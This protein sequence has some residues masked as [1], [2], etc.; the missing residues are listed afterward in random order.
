MPQRARKQIPELV[1]HR[2]DLGKL[3]CV[4]PNQSTDYVGLTSQVRV[5]QGNHGPAWLVRNGVFEKSRN[6]RGHFHRPFSPT[7]YL[8]PAT[9]NLS[10]L[11]TTPYI[12]PYRQ[13]LPNPYLLSTPSQ[14]LLATHTP[15]YSETLRDTSYPSSLFC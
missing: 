10:R 9:P 3:H 7:E 15:R 14:P 13:R 8:R 5:Q 4:V 1:E 11:R 2:Y 6:V 12:P